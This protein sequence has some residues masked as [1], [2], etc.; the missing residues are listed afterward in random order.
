MAGAEACLEYTGFI[1]RHQS[2]PYVNHVNDCLVL[3]INELII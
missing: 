3:R 1:D 2:S